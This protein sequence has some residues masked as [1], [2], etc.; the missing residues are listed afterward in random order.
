MAVVT[1]VASC[2]PIPVK[3]RGARKGETKNYQNPTIVQKKPTWRLQI[4]KR[5]GTDSFRQGQ[6]ARN[7]LR[8][9]AM[10]CIT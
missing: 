10:Y 5:H 6:A 7:V 1:L 2:D 4:R 8:Y 9:A 3:E